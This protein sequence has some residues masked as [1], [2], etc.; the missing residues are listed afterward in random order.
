MNSRF[1]ILTDQFP[2]EFFG[3]MATHA[4]NIARYLGHRHKVLVVTPRKQRDMHEKQPFKVCPALTMR[5]PA[6]DSF[7]L[8][9]V[10]RRFAP[11]VIHV[12]TAG[13]AYIPLSRSYPTVTRVVGNDFLRP[14]CGYNLP[15]RCIL[16][17]LPG[18]QTKTAVQKWET[19]IRKER[20]IEYLK[21]SHAVVANSAW[22][23][24]RLIERGVHPD[25]V[26][27]IVG[28]VDTALFQPPA[29]KRGIRAQL[30][31]P[32]ES[33]VLLTAGNLIVKKGIDTVL[34]V[35]ADLAPRWPSL[36]YVVAGDGE[37]RERLQERAADLGLGQRI[38]FAGRKDHAE[39]SL[40]YQAADLYVQ[41]SQNETMGRTYFEAGACG[42]PVI[43]AR[44][45]G[46]T[47]VVRDNLNGL[48]VSNPLD[49][50]EIRSKLEL[51]LADETLRKRL[52]A[53]GL[54]MARE[55]FSWDRVGAAFE[56]LLLAAAAS[57]PH[58]RIASPPS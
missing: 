55:E 52:G 3:G 25:R 24:D 30:N 45:E 48:L 39:L 54:R 1:L 16:Y 27:V 56:R 11:D 8:L 40:L 15:L 19:S 58:A 6:F 7:N 31:L 20:V 53:E 46:T 36:R 34:K 41:I 37:E 33:L 50:A 26:S 51:L 47:S 32:A 23:K 2:P 38:R 12:C 29:N 10:A 22:T 17:R 13:L 57:P 43:A 44:V 49:Q 35:V 28:G 4:S 42:L 14:W 5:F 9:R 18:K 21:E